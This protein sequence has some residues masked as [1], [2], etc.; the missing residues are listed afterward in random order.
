MKVFISSL[1][2]EEILVGSSKNQ[3]LSFLESRIADGDS[4]YSSVQSV[5]RV[6]EKLDFKEKDRAFFHLVQE[7]VTELIPVDSSIFEVI[8]LRNPAPISN[9]LYLEILI[10]YQSGMQEFLLGDQI[11]IKALPKL[12]LTFTQVL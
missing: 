9:E 11:D 2:W 10:A 12:R 4:F 6:W 1:I 5:L 3:V 8:T 7:L